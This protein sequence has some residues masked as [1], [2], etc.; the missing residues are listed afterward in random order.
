MLLTSDNT[1]AELVTKEL[2]VAFGSG[3][4]TAAGTE[5]MRSALAGIGMPMT[6]VLI[7][8]GSGL[9]DLNQVTCRLVQGLLDHSGPASFLGASL[10]VAGETGTLAERFE[11]STVQGRLRAKT[12]TLRQATALAGYVDT[13]AATLSFAYVVNLGAGDLVN[14]TDRLLQREL[15][16]IMAAYPQVPPL[17]EVGPQPAS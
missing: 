14:A 13:Q 4:S 3:G 8:D 2:G 10:P 15:A 6:G 16:E 11:G 12:G 9:A 5:V 1:T 17:A 7:A